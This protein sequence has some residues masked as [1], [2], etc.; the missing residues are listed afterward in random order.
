MRASLGGYR[1]HALLARSGASLLFRAEGTERG[2]AVLLEI[3][4]DQLAA[5]DG[6]AEQMTREAAA[7]AALEHPHIA[8]PVT[9]GIED[10]IAFTATPD[11]N[12]LELTP[13]VEGLGGLSLARA[14]E[15][16]CQVAAALTAAHSEGLV[17]GTLEPPRV[18]VTH[19]DGADEAIVVGFGFAP[20]PGSDAGAPRPFR[21]PV[22]DFASP[23]QI[24]GE[25]ATPA[26]DVYALGCLLY[27]ALMAEPPFAGQDETAILEAH[28]S[29]PPPAPSDRA[30]E[31]P[32][33]MDD[34]FDRALAKDPAERYG[35]P[36]EL[37][38][39]LRSIAGPGEANQTVSARKKNTTERWER[40][41]AGGPHKW[42]PSQPVW[43][44][45]GDRPATRDSDAEIEEAPSTEGEDH[46]R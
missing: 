36:D 19:N 6:F 22:A 40:S 16:V 1:I 32:P 18:L 15:I 39:D 26:S 43:P 38:A 10:G 42:S 13:L 28:L 12:G 46:F 44:Q 23:E 31:L 9:T 37:A 35:S 45:A 21:L 41:I 34:L 30:P 25:P 11:V 17:H 33:A 4:H 14:S 7:A 5:A 29:Q 3:P 27:H 2:E 8:H 24:R 20:P